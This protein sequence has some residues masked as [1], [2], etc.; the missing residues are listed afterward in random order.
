MAT[1]RPVGLRALVIFLTVIVILPLAAVRRAHA[2]G[3]GAVAAGVIAIWVTYL[4]TKSLVC[5]PVAAFNAGQHEGFGGAFKA[6]WN[7][8]P[9]RSDLESGLRDDVETTGASAAVE[10]VGGLAD[11]PAGSDSTDEGS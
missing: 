7:W 6:C 3:E 8:Q 9:G 4:T 11:N 2:Y 1:H 10:P 5:M